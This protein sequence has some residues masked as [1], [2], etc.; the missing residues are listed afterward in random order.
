MC[1]YYLRGY[2]IENTDSLVMVAPAYINMHTASQSCTA[3]IAYQ[4]LVKT[5]NSKIN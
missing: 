4:L 1:I 3:D 2:C 5:P